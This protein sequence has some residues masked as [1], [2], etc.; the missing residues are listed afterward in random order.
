MHKIAVIEDAKDNRDFLY[1]LLRD[2]YDVLRYASGQDALQAFGREAP[3]LI[4]LDI[5]LPDIDGVEVLKRI[6][7]EKTLRNVP[8]IA[9]TANAMTGDRERYLAAGFDEYVSKPIMNIDAF[10]KLI[11]GLLPPSNSAG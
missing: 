7:Q 9:L 3:D 11:R 10:V 4:V 8:T 5:W 2:E 6:R 1:Y